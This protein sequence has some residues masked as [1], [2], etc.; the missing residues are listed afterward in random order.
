MKRQ[1][2]GL[3]I[4]TGLKGLQFGHMVILLQLYVKLVRKL[5]GII[6]KI[7]ENK[8]YIKIK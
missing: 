4:F 5:F 1:E 6:L 8:Y 3:E 2:H 7:K